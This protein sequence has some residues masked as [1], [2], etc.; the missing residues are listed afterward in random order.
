M[1]GK[2]KAAVNPETLFGYGHVMLGVHG[3]LAGPWDGFLGDW[4]HS[5]A[6][7]EWV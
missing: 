6:L 1:V 7:G 4:A 3:P 5:V 2:V